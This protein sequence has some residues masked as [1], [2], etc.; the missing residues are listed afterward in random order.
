[1]KTTATLLRPNKATAYTTL[2][3]T[4]LIL[5]DFNKASLYADSSL[6]LDS[7]LLDYNGVSNNDPPFTVLQ[8]PEVTWQADIASNPNLPQSITRVDSNFYNSFD[9]NDLRKTIFFKQTSDNGYT[10]KGSYNGKWAGSSVYF[11]GV[12]TDETYLIKA[13]C[14]ARLGNIAQSLN[15]LN[16]LLAM[17]YKQGGFAPVSAA[18]AEEALKKV[19]AE[20]R[21]E[22]CFRSDIRWMDL[23]RLNQESALQ[24]T[25]SRNIDGQAFSLLPN[26]LHYAF[27]IPQNVIDNS[28]LEQNKR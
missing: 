24:V 10:F 1:M 14:Q 15:A 26:D 17:R 16:E 19:L 27:L 25:I 12:A 21:K 6:L 22:L 7:T 9:S 2:A 5:Q 3:N 4:Y 18:T 8:N 11:A 13:E 20:R 28:H 23:R